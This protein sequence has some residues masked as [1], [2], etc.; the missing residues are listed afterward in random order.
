MTLGHS[1]GMNALGHS[2]QL[3]TEPTKGGKDRGSESPPTEES[4]GTI[5]VPTIEISLNYK[6]HSIV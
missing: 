4:N 3:E 5:L 2:P 6:L 1:P